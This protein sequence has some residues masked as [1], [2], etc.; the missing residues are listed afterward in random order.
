[1]ASALPY[2]G[3]MNRECFRQGWAL[4]R[5][6]TG[7]GETNG[8]REYGKVLRN[9]DG[10]G[11]IGQRGKLEFRWLHSREW[12]MAERANSLAGGV[13]L[14]RKQVCSRRERQQSDGAE[15]QHEGKFSW[16]SQHV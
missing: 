15:D 5:R 12:R 10:P 7:R 14:V 2:A 11:M 6:R 1:M 13:M 16:V 3:P 9:Y 8:G 4:K